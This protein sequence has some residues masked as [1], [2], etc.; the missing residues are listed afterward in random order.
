MMKLQPLVSEEETTLKLM[1]S[2]NSI[3]ERAEPLWLWFPAVASK[4]TEKATRRISTRESL[5]PMEIIPS[6]CLVTR[7]IPPS[8]ENPEEKLMGT[9]E[10]RKQRQV[11]FLL[12]FHPK[13]LTRKEKTQIKEE[14]K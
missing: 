13:K 9:K 5:E 3:P 1:C 2:G 8:N 6:S 14:P 4:T 11:R 12:Q 10:P 7:K